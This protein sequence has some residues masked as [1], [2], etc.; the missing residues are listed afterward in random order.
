MY[1]YLWWLLLFALFPLVFLYLLNRKVLN[2]HKKV[3]LFAAIGGIIFGFPWD[4]LAIQERIWYF[5]KPQIIGVWILG[6]PL[7]EYIFILLETLLFATITVILLQK[8]R[9]V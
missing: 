6:L 9:N 1:S 5:T 7:E 2:S 4:Y 8:Q 3:L